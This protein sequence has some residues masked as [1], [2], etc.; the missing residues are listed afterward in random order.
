MT[1]NVPLLRKTLEHIEAHPQEWDQMYWRCETGMCFAGTACDL[2]GGQWADADGSDLLQRD[3]E[4]D[5]DNY[6]FVS[7]GLIHAATR[8]RRILGLDLLEAG[9][10]FRPGNTL[11]DLRE[12]VGRL[13]GDDQ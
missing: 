10:L 6:G 5:E 2:D 3:G 11:D 13:C 8:A 12:Q 1:V 7:P 4:P 9:W